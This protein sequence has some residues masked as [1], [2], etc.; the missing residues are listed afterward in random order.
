[1]SRYTKRELE[2]QLDILR[3]ENRRYRRALNMVNIDLDVQKTV[4]VNVNIE[5][6]VAPNEH[7]QTVLANAEREWKSNVTEPGEGGDSSRIN[8]YIKSTNCLGW[9]WEDDYQKNGDFAWCGAFA[10]AVYGVQ[11]RS[12]VRTKI[13]PSCYRLY[14]NWF[15]TSRHQD[16]EAIRPGDIVVVFTSDDKTP[17]WGNHITIARTSPDKD[18][19][20][21]TTEGNAHGVNPDQQWVE[22]VVKRTRNIKDVAHVYRLIDEDYEQ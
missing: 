10:A 7:V 19:N 22:G 8:Y 3:H 21:H 14:D 9:T 20:F 6:N 1:M 17:T 4:N 15:H 16:K 12:N 2:E 18:G 5:R 11:V 13:F